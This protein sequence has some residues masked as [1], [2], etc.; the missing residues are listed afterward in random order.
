MPFARIDLLHGKPAD[1]RATLADIVYRGIVEVLKAPDGDRF[2]VVGEHTSEESN[3]RPDV[4]RV[5]TFTQ[6]HS[7]SGYQYG[8]QRT[9]VEVCLLSIYRRRAQGQA[10]CPSG[11][12]HDQ[13]RLREAGGLVVRRGSAVDLKVQYRA[14]RRH[15][16]DKLM[17]AQA[18]PM[19][20]TRRHGRQGRV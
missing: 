6:F 1:Y 2:V 9:D 15:T 19:R 17:T 4:S 11:R 5:R 18:E 8:R 14:K 13:S 16:L 10:Q 3:L 12:Y 20:I 7:D